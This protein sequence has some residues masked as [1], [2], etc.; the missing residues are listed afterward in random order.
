MKKSIFIFSILCLAV[1]WI[2]CDDMLNVTSKTDFTD[3]NF[4]KTENDLKAACNRLYQEFEL[5]IYDL[6]ADDQF[7]RFYPNEI[8][9][10]SWSIPDQSADWTNPYHSIFTANNILV[11]AENA[12]ISE[13]I[14]NRY[15]SEARFFRA[16]HYF[17]LVCKYGDVPLV[18]KPFS[19]T[20]DPGL[21]MNRTP[22][23]TVIQQCY[24][25]LEYAAEWLP[26]RA[27]M[28]AVNDE[29][30]R[31]RVTRSAALALMVRI[32]LHEGTMQKYH[33]LS[34]E[35]VWKA[36][37]QKSID[38]Y[39]LLKVEGHQ[40]Y[41]NGSAS[42]SYGNAPV[43]YMALFFDEV[44]SSNK[45]VIFS[46]AY[47]PNG[48]TGSNAFLHGRSRSCDI[49]FNITRSMVDYYLYADGLPREK[50]PLVFT[51]E[52]SFNHIL[53]YETD[54][55]TPIA[56]GMGARDPRLP[57][58]VLLFNDPQHD[59]NAKILDV[60]VSYQLTGHGGKY[61]PLDSSKPCGYVCKKGFSGPRYSEDFTDIIVIRWGEMLISYAEALYEIN[62][63]ITDAQLNETV[64]ALRDRV[65]FAVPLTNSFAAANGLNMLEEIRRERTVELMA[66]NRRYADIIRWKIAETVLPKAI[67]GAKFNENEASNGPAQAADPSFA[68]LYTDA[69]GKIAGVQE[70]AYP[71][72]NIRIA[73]KASTR[74][75]N[76][77]KDYFYP[78]PSYE[79]A[80]S[81]GN[82][83][84]NPGW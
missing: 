64:N 67:V 9:N 43:G 12:P 24:A 61:L 42:V 19:G 31:R 63:A 18:L 17:E 45:E 48:I 40:L 26:T 76:P 29:F 52:T 37:L 84:Q 27:A 35:L 62:G 15:L 56:N 79:I 41:T 82:I 44:N 83:T 71:E 4:W 75:F 69:S 53:G 49:D 14:R 16:W 6:R 23:E 2:G 8:S 80:Q 21:K 13:N 72:A 25:D 20:T 70:Y 38:A 81:G 11:K 51:P 55:I 22:R 32:G 66:E 10:G 46:K 30:D 39:N 50:S 58:S 3:N 78:I 34:N 1:A 54:G 65:G 28:E 5:L 60:L 7:G 36:H 77:A 74:R 59:V 73:E 47:G 68:E 57:M 33:N